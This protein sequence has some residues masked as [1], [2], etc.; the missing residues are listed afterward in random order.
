MLRNTN[1]L[2]HTATNHAI[3]GHDESYRQF[4][5][6]EFDYGARWVLHTGKKHSHIIGD[7]GAWHLAPTPRPKTYPLYIS[8]CYAQTRLK[9]EKYLRQRG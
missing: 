5:P 6:L 4:A 1:L 3:G 7:G 2:V 8:L 9:Y